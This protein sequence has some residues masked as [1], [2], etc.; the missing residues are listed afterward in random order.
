MG[1]QPLLLG[2]FDFPEGAFDLLNIFNLFFWALCG[3]L[4]WLIGTWYY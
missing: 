2:A 3:L 1:A 4:Y